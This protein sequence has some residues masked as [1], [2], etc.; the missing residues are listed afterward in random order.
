VL[1]DG[2]GEVML[3]QVGTPDRAAITEAVEQLASE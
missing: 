1:L 2:A 3:T